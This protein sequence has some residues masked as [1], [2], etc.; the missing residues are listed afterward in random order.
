MTRGQ[1]RCR[2]D[3]M[4]TDERAHEHLGGSQQREVDHECVVLKRRD[5]ALGADE[6]CCNVGLPVAAFLRT[7]LRTA[8]SPFPAYT[9][10]ALQIESLR[11]RL[12]AQAISV[13]CKR[14]CQGDQN[15]TLYGP[16]MSTHSGSCDV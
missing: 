6:A 13:R 12:G 4:K 14:P 1:P 10:C 3:T 2:H 11:F 7:Q 9:V 15:L 5:V 8:D 16:A